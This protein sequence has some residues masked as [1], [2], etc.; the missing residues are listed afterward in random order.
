[1]TLLLWLSLVFKQ[2]TSLG[3]DHYGAP[4]QAKLLLWSF[5]GFRYHLK[6]ALVASTCFEASQ[7]SELG[8]LR[9]SRAGQ[10]AVI[11]L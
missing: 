11:E 1:M 5:E 8:P 4:V 3:G 10:V 2:L 7:K 9:R 6:L